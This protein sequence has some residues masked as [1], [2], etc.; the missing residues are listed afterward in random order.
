MKHCHISTTLVAALFAVSAFADAFDEMPASVRRIALNDILSD[1]TEVTSEKFPDAD[2]VLMDSVTFVEYNADG[3][4]VTYDDTYVKV[5]TEKGRRGAMTD[6]LHFNVVYCTNEI[7]A[8]QVIKADGSVQNV[9]VERNTSIMTDTSSMGSNIYDP[10]D[11]ILKISYPGVEIGDIVRLAFKETEYKV[12]VPDMWFDYRTFESFSP[13]R[14][15]T[16]AVSSPDERPIRKSCIRARVEN[17]MTSRT[18]DLPDAKRRITIWDVRDVPQAFPEPEMP[19][20]YTV[21]QRLL[22]STAENWKDLSKW[23]WNLCR[24]RLESTTPEMKATVEKIVAESPDDKVRSIFTW[25]S[26]NVRY[27]GVTTET[28]APGYEPHDVSMTFANRYGVCRDKAAL[29]VAMLRM[30]GVDAYPVLIHAGEKRDHEVPMS[31]FNHAIVAVREKDGSYTLMDPTVESAHDLLPAYLDDKSYLVAHPDGE[32]L[33]VSAITPATANMLKIRSKGAIDDKGTL[34][35]TADIAFEGINDNVYRGGFLRM[36]LEKRRDFFDGLAKRIIPGASLVAFSLLPED[37]QDTDSPL[38]ASL[39]ISAKDYL[40]KGEKAVLLNVPWMSQSLGYVNFILGSTGLEKRKYPLV[41]ETACGTDETI[42][43]SLSES[44]ASIAMPETILFSTNGVT[45]AQS[46][47]NWPGENRISAGRRFE[48]NYVE[49]QPEIYSGFKEALSDIEHALDGRVVLEPQDENTGA[50]VRI[51]SKDIRYDLVTPHAWT[52]TVSTVT[53]ILT[54]AGRKRSSELTITYNPSWQDV[55]L[56]YAT[57]SNANGVV[58]SVQPHEINIMDQGWVAS[59]PRYPAGKTMVISLPGVETGSVIRTSYRI[60]RRERASSAPEAVFFSSSPI[61]ASSD[62]L[63][64]YLVTISAPET[65]RLRWVTHGDVGENITMANGSVVRRWSVHMPRRIPREEN[66]PPAFAYAP[67]LHVSAGDWKEYASSIA[68]VLRDA[69]KS[70]KN[71][72]TRRKARELCDPIKETTDKVRAIRDFVARDIRTA[73]PSFTDIPLLVSQPDVTIADGYGN[74]LDKAAVLVVMLDAIGLDADV[75]LAD[76]Q[77]MLIS[78]NGGDDDPRY[79]YPS[80]GVFT[81]PLVLVEPERGRRV[82]LNDTDQYADIGMTPSDRHSA[83]VLSSRSLTDRLDDITGEDDAGSSGE[84]GAGSRVTVSVPERDLVS[85][86]ELERVIELDADG[87]AI[88]TVKESAYGMNVAAKRRKYTEMTPEELSRHHQELVGALSV[89]AKPLS[90]LVVET[91]GAA[92]VV[93]F[94]A[95]APRYAFKSGDTITLA[96]GR[97]GPVMSFRSD[98]R[99]LPIG[100]SAA[101]DVVQTTIVVLPPEAEEILLMPE[102]IEW[103]YFGIGDILRRTNVFTRE[104]GRRCIRIEAVRKNRYRSVIGPEFYPALLEMNRKITSPLQGTIIVRLK[105]R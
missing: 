52:T 13:I 24:P 31:S 56:L 98:K 34:S 66:L 76:N 8:A 73:G 37:L 96:L 28:E 75:V 91:N 68:A 38:T 9:D 69:V 72:V 26:Q 19:A 33:R 14:R 20:M 23:Y 45:F 25:V 104:D 39:T 105:Y 59:A 92:F 99:H 60:V 74:S 61:F 11:K 3:T 44:V 18:V 58:K 42:D 102:D 67:T 79:E 5:L 7:I 53:E 16:Y 94:S 62:I 51:I 97:P 40:A 84:G 1:S 103:S 32:D 21:A 48:L 95:T 78:A 15:Y 63:D 54:Y 64:D 57:V 71:V 49:Y 46:A 12:R 43:I 93:T 81:R 50:D 41:T 17:T 22:L 90:P 88:V 27:M 10:N 100:T 83:L 36:P 6:S 65:M 35:L 30:A 47:T 80:C 82:Y 4:S 55:E 77:R 101:E 70:G 86:G 29:L 89:A 85:R 2:D 87:N